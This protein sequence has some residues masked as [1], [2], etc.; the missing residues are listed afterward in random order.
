MYSPLSSSSDLAFVSRWRG[1]REVQK[2]QNVT[3]QAEEV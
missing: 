2:F 1:S 3:P